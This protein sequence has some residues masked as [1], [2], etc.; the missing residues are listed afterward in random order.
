MADDNS[1][2]LSQAEVEAILQSIGKGDD[3][4]DVKVVSTGK[5]RDQPAH[6]ESYDFKSPVFLSPGELRRLR[7]KHEDYIRSLA[8]TLSMF[9]RME[10]SVQMSKLETVAFKHLVDQLP[11]PSHLTI[12]KVHPMGALCLFDINP[13]LALTIIDRLTG[14]PGH[15]IKTERDLTDIEVEVLKNFTDIVLTEY[16][17]SWNKYQQLDW[18]LLEHENTARF[19]KI[20]DPDEVMLFLDMEVRFGDCLAGMRYVIPYHTIEHLVQ[21][22]MKEISRNPEDDLAFKLPE[23]PNAPQ[24][25][26]PVPVSV[27][28]DAFT[29]SLRQVDEMKVGDLLILDKKKCDQAVVELGNLPKFKGKVNM[30][31]EKKRV[32]LLNKI[33]E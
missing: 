8:G 31:S 2:V 18:E 16:V 27:Y 30:E 12:F 24:Y 13:R 21:A 14:G 1:E 20:V 32:E 28:W 22:L 26:I 19:L 3:T 7:I 29:M 15:S 6:V 5:K 17:Q 25:S 10:F 33:K 4:D 23:N 9:L 11:M